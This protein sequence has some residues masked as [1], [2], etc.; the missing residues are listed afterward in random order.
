MRNC[1]GYVVLHCVFVLTYMQVDE[2]TPIHL[3]SSSH[4]LTNSGLT[5]PSGPLSPSSPIARAEGSAYHLHFHDQ[6]GFQYQTTG[7]KRHRTASTKVY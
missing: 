6:I 3:P 7:G 1:H 2:S 5:S 4:A